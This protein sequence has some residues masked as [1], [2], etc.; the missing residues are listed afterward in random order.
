MSAATS[1]SLTAALELT[2]GATRRS[3]RSSFAKTNADL[4]DNII[5]PSNKIHRQQ[6]SRKSMVLSSDSRVEVHHYNHDLFSSSLEGTLSRLQS[7]QQLGRL[8]INGTEL[9]SSSANIHTDTFS[10][11]NLCECGRRDLS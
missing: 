11:S 8:D 5:H 6:T 1:R 10:N 9:H 2:R 4:N 7:M 3:V